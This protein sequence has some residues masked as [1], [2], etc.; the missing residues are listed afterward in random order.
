MVTA[1]EKGKFEDMANMSKTCQER[2]METHSPTLKGS[3]R[4]VQGSKRTRGPPLDFVFCS[5]YQRRDRGLPVGEVA[6]KPGEMRR[7]LL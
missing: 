6:E 2:G 3:K 4:E 1:K 5:E 7:T